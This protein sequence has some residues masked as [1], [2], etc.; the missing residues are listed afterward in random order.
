MTLICSNHCHRVRSDSRMS[1]LMNRQ[2]TVTCLWCLMWRKTKCAKKRKKRKNM[3]MKFLQTIRR[4]FWVRLGCTIIF[5]DF[6]N[7][8]Y[9]L[10]LFFWTVTRI[11]LQ[12]NAL[13]KPMHCKNSLISSKVRKSPANSCILSPKITRSSHMRTNLLFFEF[14]KIPEFAL[15]GNFQPFV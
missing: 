11:I 15:V 1:C 6:S 5:E 14:K 13:I 8:F 3:K 12:I 2:V 4:C 10:L 9:K 7:E